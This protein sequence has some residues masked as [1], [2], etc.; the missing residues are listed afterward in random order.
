MFKRV[1]PLIILMLFAALIT[2]LPLDAQAVGETS[3]VFQLSSDGQSYIVSACDNSATGVIEIPAE[4]NGKLVTEIGD[5][6]FQFCYYLTDVIIPD[7]VISIGVS[8]FSDCHG[9][10]SIV[11]PDSVTSIGSMAFYGCSQLV[12]VTLPRV[13]HRSARVCSN[14]VADCRRL[15][16][17][18]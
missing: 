15:I 18:T 9:L 6:A 14:A 7:T 1:V 10:T 3:L 16:F 12:N 5:K 11:I 2:F 8:A 4:Y 17:L 13:L